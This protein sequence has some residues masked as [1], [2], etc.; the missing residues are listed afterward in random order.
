MREFRTQDGN[1]I[2]LPNDQQRPTSTVTPREFYHC[3]CHARMGNDFYF[4]PMNSCLRK[5]KT[6]DNLKGQALDG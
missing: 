5:D 6:C 1:I 2:H 4:L 3:W